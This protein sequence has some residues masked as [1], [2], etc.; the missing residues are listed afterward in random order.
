MDEISFIM[1]DMFD[2]SNNGFLMKFGN[3]A[4]I[5]IIRHPETSWRALNKIWLINSLIDTYCIN[6]KVWL[7]HSN[8]LDIFSFLSAES[9]GH[10]KLRELYVFFSKQ[11]AA[12]V[13]R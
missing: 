10:Q 2:S 9:D 3:T 5:E 6:M 4:S 12:G 7:L 11:M 1:V 8:L 13:Y